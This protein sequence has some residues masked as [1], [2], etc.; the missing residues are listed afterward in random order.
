[1]SSLK[2]EISAVKMD[3]K[4]SHNYFASVKWRHISK[5]ALNGGVKY[6]FVNAK[7]EITENQ[8]W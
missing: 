6:P 8:K 2:T 5:T 4:A 1:M 7:E 3:R